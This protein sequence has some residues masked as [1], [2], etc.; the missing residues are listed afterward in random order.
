MKNW[1]FTT[2]AVAGFSFS[3]FGVALIIL[4][5][6]T[7]NAFLT[8]L[9]WMAGVALLIGGSLSVRAHLLWSRGDTQ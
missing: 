2:C 4:N 6:V 8:V 9:L 1:S 3:A 5:A 7:A